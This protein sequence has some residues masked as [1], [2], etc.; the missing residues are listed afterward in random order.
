M[1]TARPVAA[2]LSDMWISLL[3]LSACRPEAPLGPRPGDDDDDDVTGDDDDVLVFPHDTSTTP[4][5]VGE[6][7]V[8]AHGGVGTAGGVG[9][10]YVFDAQ[11]PVEVEVGGLPVELL[12]SGVA[13]AVVFRIPDLPPGDHGFVLRSPFGDRETRTL[14]LVEPDFVDVAEAY[15]LDDVHDTSGQPAECAESLTGLAFADFDLDGDPDA[16][17]G[18]FGPTTRVLRN[19][20]TAREPRF[21]DVDMAATGV[22]AVGALAVADVDADGDPDLW[23][24]RKGANLLFVNQRVETGTW[25]FVE[26]SVAL[27]LVDPVPGRTM[28][29]VFG[30]PNGDGHLDLYEINHTFCFPGGKLEEEGADAFF[31]GTPSGF[32][33]RTGV[34]PDAE[35][36]VSS[37]YGFSGVWVD[38][39]R[40]GDQDLFV[41]NDFVAGGG[42]SVQLRNLDPRTLSF[43]SV[44]RETGFAMHPDPVF[45]T[46]NGMNVAV[47]DLNHDGHPDFAISNIGPNVVLMSD[48]STGEVTYRDQGAPMGVQRNLLP[49]GQ[50]SVTWGGH[51]FDYDNDGHVDLFFVGGPIRFGFAMPHALFRN[52]GDGTFDDVT[53]TSGLS[54]PGHGKGTALVDFDDDGYLDVVVAN[55]GEPLEVYRNAAGDRLGHHWLA[56]DLVGDGDVHPDAFGAI[57]ELVDAAG[58]LHTCFHTPQPALSAAGDHACR[59]GLGQATSVTSARVIWPDGRAQ[60]VS[61][62]GVDR[63][64]RVEA[65]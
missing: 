46:L 4:D 13:G 54:G 63:R 42:P 65:L 58:Q 47:A 12:A 10:A 39:D 64:I 34:L 35:G 56:F 8:I 1:G 38:D 19:E 50:Q 29:A 27:G 21:V 28:G 16:V 53:F 44:G 18:H 57:V 25:S 52:R 55:W 22:D 6:P 60:A 26:R 9:W 20:G 59:F 23:V 31:L 2:T 32:E 7:I 14:T 48:T 5:I 15:G 43:A 49:W 40:D 41:V 45:K 51:L 3:L 62:P 37:R 24:G 33:E 30:D 11:M 36:V 61:V 17:L